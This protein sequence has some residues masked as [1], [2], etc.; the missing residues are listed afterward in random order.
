MLYA[1]FDYVDIKPHEYLILPLT[2][3]SY[4][5]YYREFVY[6]YTNLQCIEITLIQWIYNRYIEHDLLL[7]SLMLRERIQYKHYHKDC[8]CNYRSGSYYRIE[9]RLRTLRL[10]IAF[11]DPSERLDLYLASALHVHCSRL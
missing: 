8:L 4:N 6:D 2:E 9:S 11:Q 1:L 5:R 3:E 10:Y 7:P